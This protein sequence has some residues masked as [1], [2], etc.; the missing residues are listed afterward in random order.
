MKTETGGRETAAS[1][2]MTMAGTS[3]QEA[4]RSRTGQVIDGRAIAS[5]LKAE[6]AREVKELHADGFTA[7]IATLL[8]GGDYAARAYEQRIGKMAAELGVAWHQRQLPGDVSQPEVLAAIDR[9]NADPVVSGTLIL[10][11]VPAHIREEE[12][13]T[14]LEPEKDIEAVHPQNA[15]LLARSH[16]QL[17]F[18]RHWPGRPSSAATM[19]TTHYPLLM[20]LR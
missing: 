15:G 7:G 17:T 6:V 8:I 20:R 16:H 9:L 5:D 12:I 18:S 3:A 1:G 19:E 4:E 11:P 2:M 14:A 10:R 13:F